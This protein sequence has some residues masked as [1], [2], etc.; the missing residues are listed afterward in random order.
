MSGPSEKRYQDWILVKLMERYPESLWERQNVVAAKAEGRDGKK[1]FIRAGTPGQGDIRG[2]HL[3]WYIELEVK[4]PGEQQSQKQRDR[5]E[6]I[7]IARGVY[8]VIHNPTEA[9]AVVDAL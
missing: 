5:Q 7:R 3:G 2:C 6:R 1:R 8:A 9:F 4:R